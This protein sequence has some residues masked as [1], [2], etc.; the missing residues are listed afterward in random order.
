[1]D[2][3]VEEGELKPLKR[4]KVTPGNPGVQSLTNQPIMKKNWRD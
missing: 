3:I 1:M 4:F 2:Q